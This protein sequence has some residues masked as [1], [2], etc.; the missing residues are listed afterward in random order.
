MA[1]NL[2]QHAFVFNLCTDRYQYLV[3]FCAAMLAG[4]CTLMPPNR[5]P[6]T[7]QQLAQQYPDSYSLVDDDALLSAIFA[8]SDAD[9]TAVEIPTIPVN[10]LC[11]VAFTSGST[12]APSPNLKYWKTLRSSS[13]GNAELMLPKDAE[14]LNLVATVPPQH[15]WGMETSILLPLFANVAISDQ[16]PFYPQD[17]ADAMHKLPAPRALVSSP[18]HLNVLCKSNVELKELAYIFS[19]TAP[20]SQELAVQLE[21]QFSTQLVEVFGSSESGIVARRQTSTESLWQLSEL[22]S[23]LVA[24]DGTATIDA[25]HLPGSVLISDVIELV[26]EQHF[27]W[28]GRHQDMLNIAGKRGSL[29]DLN[30]RLLAIDGVEDG[31]IFLRADQSERLAAM[32]VAPDKQAKQILAELKAEIESV[33]LPRPLLL[34]DALPRQETGKLT[35]RDILQKFADASAQQTGV[36]V[37]PGTSNSR[38]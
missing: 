7:L 2:P 6:A 31:V 30:R 38:V 33:F 19:A 34:V 28:L 5:L 16:T 37:K 21:K 32:V 1:A 12:G 26:G 22:F 24:D 8:H 18:V 35:Q 15:M 23:L 36:A 14:R 27:R 17:I 29:A 4:Q 11:A 20:M 10:Q 25:E 3:G 13:L 9:Q